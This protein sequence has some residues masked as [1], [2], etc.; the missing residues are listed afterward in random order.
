MLEKGQ[1]A[2]G[3]NRSFHDHKVYVIMIL[4]IPAKEES[5]ALAL[6]SLKD[7]SFPSS[8][9]IVIKHT[10]D[11]GYFPGFKTYWVESGA[12]YVI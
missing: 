6:F 4:K 11:W 2:E 3:E 9:I 12:C 7:S 1:A 5:W 10:D 8:I